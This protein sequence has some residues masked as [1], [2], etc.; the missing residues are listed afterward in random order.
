MQVRYI[1]RFLYSSVVD[2]ALLVIYWYMSSSAFRVYQASAFHVL[3]ACVFPRE[4]KL[5]SDTVGWCPAIPSQTQCM[6][7]CQGILITA[8]GLQG[9]EPL[10][11]RAM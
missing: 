10:V 9:E 7:T 1:Y 5:W 2:K 3:T 11:N 4:L 6:Y 8:S